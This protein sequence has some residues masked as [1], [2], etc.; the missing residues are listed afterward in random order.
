MVQ[1]E[2]NMD[3]KLMKEDD[4]QIDGNEELKVGTFE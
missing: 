4:E 2:V 1:D 3:S